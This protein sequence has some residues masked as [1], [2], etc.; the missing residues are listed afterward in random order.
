[1]GKIEELWS[2]GGKFKQTGPSMAL[3]EQL[4]ERHT[5]DKAKG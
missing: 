1:M 2:S 3:W 4:Q 5:K